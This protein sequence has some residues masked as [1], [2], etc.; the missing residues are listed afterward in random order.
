MSK[1]V[2]FAS[3]P[4]VMFMTTMFVSSTFAW[5]TDF[6]VNS[7]NRVQS[8]N[9]AVGF[10][11]SDSIVNSNLSGEVQDLKL[12]SDPVFNLGNAAQ[13]GDS[14]ER[15]LRIRNEGNIAINYQVDFAV[16]VDS[17]LAEVV[18][19]EIQPLGG[20][21]TTVVGTN[22]DQ[23]IYITL[24]DNAQGTGG[25]LRPSSETPQEFE[26]WRVKMIYTSRADN[27]YNDENLVFEVDI[28][29]NAW[30]FNYQESQGSIPSQSSS[31]LTS[32]TSSQ[33]S[34]STITS[35]VSSSNSFN[36]MEITPLVDIYDKNVNDIAYSEGEV[37]YIS[38][39]QREVV[40]SDGTTHAYIRNSIALNVTLGQFIGVQYVI[41]TFRGMVQLTNVTLSAPKGTAPIINVSPQTLTAEK[42][43][44]IASASIFG[45]SYVTVDLI[46]F[47]SG[48]FT[49]GYLAGFGPR[50]VQTNA[51]PST[52]R[53]K[54]FTVTGWI[55]AR[56]NSVFPN[57]AVSITLISTVNYEGVHANATIPTDE[58]KL[59]LA[60]EHFIPPSSND[61]LV[62]NLI[63][64]TQGILGSTIV[65][66]SS[67]P[68]ALSTTG[69]VTRPSIGQFSAHVDLSYV[70]TLG[71]VS[72]EPVTIPFIILSIPEV[73]NAQTLVINQ[74]NFSAPPSNSLPTLEEVFRRSG[75]TSYQPNFMN[76][77][78]SLVNNEQAQAGGFFTRNKINIGNS[79][80]AGFSTYF[81]MLQSGGRNLLSDGSSGFGD[82]FTF[83][84]AKDNNVLGATGG[85]M[86]YG[87]IT[88]SV[89]I[90]FDTF[91]NGNQPP[92]CVSL[93]MNGAQGV[94]SYVGDFKEATLRIW[95]DYSRNLKTL[96]V[97]INPTNSIRPVNPTIA[98]NNLELSNLGDEFFAGFTSATGGAVQNTILNKW[99]LSNTYLSEGILINTVTE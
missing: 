39:N 51:A 9:L 82:G 55:L 50:F 63:L 68:G 69:V 81:E 44:N 23:G 77:S 89:A 38:A 84:L 90:L 49:N 20:S 10:A 65:W 40:I 71:D 59:A 13:P 29:L 86:G 28:R 43:L 47:A 56:G 99:Y 25:L 36:Q 64:P 79:D 15:Y 21:T 92:M 73:L 96:E 62:E 18:D 5:F 76:G 16:T 2:W 57:P 93:G 80:Q 66:S 12:D 42:A 27:T 4:S 6:A 26:I 78:V 70:I 3:V 30:Q 17:R 75:S 53:D 46:G 48:S 88:N 58:E 97:R 60:M 85:A 7:G 98:F 19:F 67:N 52:L 72:T 74:P 41:N 14:Q 95:I 8:G 91:D 11:A 1:K 22:I 61:A 33:S 37:L 34:S 35:S 31:S 83:V 87:G 45:P 54:K 94:C 32:T 24:Q